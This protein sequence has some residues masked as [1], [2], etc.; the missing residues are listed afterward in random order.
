MLL[1]ASQRKKIEYGSAGII[2]FFLICSLIFR[3][4]V[5]FKWPVF[6]QPLLF[7]NAF[8]VS[9][10]IILTSKYIFRSE[11]VRRESAAM[12]LR[13]AIALSL[14]LN[15]L[16]ELYLYE[17]YKYGFQYDKFLHLLCPIMFMPILALF[18]DTWFGWSKKRAALIAVSVVLLFSVIWE[19]FEF[20]SDMIFKTQEFGIYGKFKVTD[21]FFDLLYDLSGTVIAYVIISTRQ[22]SKVLFENSVLALK[23]RK[24]TK[25]AL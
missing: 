20:S 11:N 5:N 8:L 17:L 3:I 4:F 13:F 16:G 18:G 23:M 9:A 12:L 15:A 7:S 22:F 2:F 1:N 10:V 6:Y 24:K 21:T 19:V 25:G 14:F